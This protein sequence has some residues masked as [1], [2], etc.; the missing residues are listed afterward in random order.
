[1]SVH[2]DGRRIPSSQLRGAHL[3]LDKPAHNPY[4]APATLGETRGQC[5]RKGKQVI[6][7]TG[8]TLPHRCVKCNAPAEMDKAKTYSWHHP[9]YYLLIFP[10]LLFYI[11]AALVATKRAKVAIGVCQQHRNRRR[12]FGGIALGMFILGV[13]TLFMAVNTQVE[14]SP[15]GLVSG[16]SFFA[17][18]IIGS[19]GT[20]MLSAAR[21]TR[22]EARLNGCGDEFLSS[23]PQA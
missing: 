2:A 14:G 7:P 23:L 22:D 8:A 1:M 4:A 5:Y 17:A 15:L 6:V 12:M 10:G 13:V 11:V 21:V 20:R 3:N 9:A 19:F 18:L 16:L